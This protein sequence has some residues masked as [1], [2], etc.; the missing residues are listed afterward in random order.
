MGVKVKEDY[1]DRKDYSSKERV[2]GDR[3]QEEEVK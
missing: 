1:K 3:K 2:G